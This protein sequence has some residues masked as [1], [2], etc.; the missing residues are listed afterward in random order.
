M[1]VV[2]KVLPSRLGGTWLVVHTQ[3]TRIDRCRLNTVGYRILADILV[4]ILLCTS[5][6]ASQHGKIEVFV[7]EG[8]CEDQLHTRTH[9]ELVGLGIGDE[10]IILIRISAVRE[11]SWHIGRLRIGINVEV[12]APVEGQAVLVDAGAEKLVLDVEVRYDA[13]GLFLLP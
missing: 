10:V 7:L 1:S 9:L 11:T 6:V 13:I 4:G 3:Q 2:D 5:L 8:R 12:H